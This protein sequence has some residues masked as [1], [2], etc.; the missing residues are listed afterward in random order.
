VPVTLFA[1]TVFADSATA[2]WSS[3]LVGYADGE[4]ELLAHFTQLGSK[5]VCNNS[6]L[7]GS[8]AP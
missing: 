7:G 4:R 6:T 2:W 1:L 5:G 8:F 3:T